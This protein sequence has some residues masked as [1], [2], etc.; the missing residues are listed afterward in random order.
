MVMIF[1]GSCPEGCWGQLAKESDVGVERAG[2]GDKN[3]FR[4][5]A[6]ETSS[7]FASWYL[8]FHYCVKHGITSV[9]LR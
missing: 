1:A 4:K 5:S 2:V 7:Y 6:C 8:R 9:A 3:T